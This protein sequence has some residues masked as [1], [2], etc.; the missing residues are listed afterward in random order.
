MKIIRT[1]FDEKVAELA[2]ERVVLAIGVFDGVHVGHRFLL[3]RAA[4][5]ADEVEAVVA[6]YTFWPYPTHFYA[7]N[8]KEA[9]MPSERKFEILAGLGVHYA[10]EQCFDEK[11]AAISHKKFIDFLRKKFQFL[12]GIC[13]GSDFKFGHNRAGDVLSLQKFCGD[14]NIALRVADEFCASGERVS[15]SRIRALIEGRDFIAANRLL[16]GEIFR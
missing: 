6:V 16:G 13:V 7:K 10:I 4:K 2:E 14:G 15:S 3:K 8:W 12:S 9:I 11:F 5:F 1:S